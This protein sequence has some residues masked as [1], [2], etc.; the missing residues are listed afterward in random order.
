MN[1]YNEQTATAEKLSC[2]ASKRMKEKITYKY[3]DL[4]C[5]HERYTC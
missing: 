5:V 2:N 1:I 4:L 3:L